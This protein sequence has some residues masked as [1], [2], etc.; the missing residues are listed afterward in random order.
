MSENATVETEYCGTFENNKIEKK[1][2][3]ATGV[4]C[5]EKMTL[6]RNVEGKKSR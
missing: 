5:Q 1:C 3:V 2:A 6:R 4:F